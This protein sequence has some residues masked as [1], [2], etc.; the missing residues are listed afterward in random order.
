VGGSVGALVALCVLAETDL[1]VDAVA[2]VSPAIRLPAVVALNERR[3]GFSY[4]WTERSRAAAARLDFLARAEEI[5]KRDAAVLLVA[6]ALDD[7][8]G[9]R[10]PAEQFWHVLSR[11]APDRTALSSI[12]QMAHALAEEPGLD[13]APQTP[14]AARVDTVVTGWFDCHLIGSRPAS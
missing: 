8:E 11:H 2:L 9:I 4:P 12:P 13:P 3:F 5:V 6:G 7:E 10:A 14:H 1:P